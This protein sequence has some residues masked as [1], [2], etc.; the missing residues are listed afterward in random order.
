MKIF[1][2]SL[3]L[4]LSISTFSKKKSATIQSVWSA[5]VSEY[6]NKYDD[7]KDAKEEF[8]Q[9]YRDIYKKDK[10]KH[11]L[12]RESIVMKE[13]NEVADMKK[14]HAKNLSTQTAD[15]MH[16]LLFNNI[17]TQLDEAKIHN[18]Y[19]V[20]YAE[21]EYEKEKSLKLLTLEKADKLVAMAK[22][23]GVYDYP[24]PKISTITKPKRTKE[25]RFNKSKKK[26]YRRYASSA[27]RLYRE[28]KLFHHWP[29]HNII[30]NDI[31]FEYDLKQI[32]I[33]KKMTDKKEVILNDYLAQ[34]KAKTSNQLQSD[35]K[36]IGQ[37]MM[38]E[39]LAMDIEFRAETKRLDKE[40]KIKI[41]QK[42]RS[43]S[44]LF[45]KK[46]RDHEKVLRA[47]AS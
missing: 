46:I 18:K 7:Y 23:M 16:L 43:F 26:I 3:L 47:K 4:V 14:K 44:S 28:M 12:I 20:K 5:Q 24:F 9:E 40:M 30:R 1:F 31:R 35:S 25:R 38:K 45:E 29:N 33:R 6:K 8:N 32:A 10:N 37:K 36:L 17:A 2:L 13:A 41:K 11:S 15:Q 42:Q 22:K 34:I 19:R 27:S 39:A 21:I